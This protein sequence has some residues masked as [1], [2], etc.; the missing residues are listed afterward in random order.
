RWCIWDPLNRDNISGNEGL[1]DFSKAKVVVALDSDFL[2]A[3]P[4]A[5]RYARDFSNARRIIDVGGAQMSRFYAAEPTP[6]IT[7]SNADHRIAVAARDILP[8]AQA[9]ATRAGLTE[10]DGKIQHP[11]Q[12]WI[13]AVVRDLKANRGA[14]IIIAGETQPP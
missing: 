1:C 6:T 5:L 9:I 3:H 14:S 13:E 4:Y 10:L 11:W 2:Y 12:D 7:G 8:L